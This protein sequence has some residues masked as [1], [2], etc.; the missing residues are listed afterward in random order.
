MRRG[1]AIFLTLLA[2]V[3]VVAM[4]ADFGTAQTQGPISPGARRPPG[5]PPD[6]S[7]PASDAPVENPGVNLPSVETRPRQPI[8]DRAHAACVGRQTRHGR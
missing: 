5:R 2:A 6:P 7:G 8:P 3:T 1:H 4:V